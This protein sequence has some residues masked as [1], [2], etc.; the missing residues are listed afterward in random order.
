MEEWGGGGG[1]RERQRLC[2][3]VGVE[4]LGQAYGL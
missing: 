3:S 1:G 4:I 2:V